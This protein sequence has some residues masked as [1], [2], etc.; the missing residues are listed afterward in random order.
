[1]LESSD[2]KRSDILNSLI[3]SKSNLLKKNTHIEQRLNKI[4]RVK[5]ENL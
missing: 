3:K 5:T 1:M 4:I 2:R